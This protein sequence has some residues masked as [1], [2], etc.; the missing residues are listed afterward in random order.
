[1]LTANASNAKARV[2]LSKYVSPRARKRVKSKRDI[3]S[4][5]RERKENLNCWNASSFRPSKNL[6]HRGHGEHRGTPQRCPRLIG[7]GLT[8]APVP[9]FRLRIESAAISVNRSVS[10]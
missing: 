10:P 5:L 3:T 6:N 1:M 8:S 9:S 7:Y 4:G 2:D